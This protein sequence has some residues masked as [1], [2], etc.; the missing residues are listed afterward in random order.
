MNSIQAQ[1]ANRILRLLKRAD[2]THVGLAPGSRSTPLVTA[3]TQHWDPSRITVH[4]DERGLGFWGLGVGKASGHPA[5]II[6]TSGTA[7][8]NL[9]PSAIEA[10]YSNVPIIF[11]TADRPSDLVGV[12]A[13]QA[14]RQH[15]VLSNYCRFSVDLHPPTDEIQASYWLQRV[16]EGLGVLK[17][18]A[19]GPIHFNVRFREPLWDA[20]VTIDSALPLPG[21]W[22]LPSGT[23]SLVPPIVAGSV[24]VGEYG[25]TEQL[26][27]VILDSTVPIWVD[28]LS[29]TISHESRFF[30][31]AEWH[32]SPINLPDPLVILGGKIHSKVLNQSIQHHVGTVVQLTSYPYIQDPNHRVDCQMVG[33][34]HHLAGALT[35]NATDYNY[36]IRRPSIGSQWSELSAMAAIVPYLNEN[37]SVFI[38]NSLAIR[39]LDWLRPILSNRFIAQFN[40]GASGID[41]LIATTHG[42]AQSSAAPTIAIIGDLSALHDLNSLA[43][44][45][46]EAADHPLIIVVLNNRGGG[47]FTQL[48]IVTHPN[49]EPYFRT[50]HSFNFEFPARQFNYQYHHIDSLDEAR[51]RIPAILS[52]SGRHLIELVVEPDAIGDHL[53]IIRSKWGY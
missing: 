21:G 4:F 2:V 40:R 20:Q 52:Q 39:C 38:G 3:L 18:G 6:V 50:P 41:G 27:D 37:W 30:T 15:D 47:L 31:D 11:L 43:F 16:N 10:F 48:P 53:S 29:G 5:I 12:G 26:P 51:S 45:A 23:P 32:T 22:S 46:Y 1:T 9:L 34:L 35:P 7:V 36:S 8:A 28:M 25:S 33:P 14:I 42:I 49:F 19:P 13:N 44:G 24:I 17:S